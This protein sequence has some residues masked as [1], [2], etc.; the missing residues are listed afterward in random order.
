MDT[1]F[2]FVSL[3]YEIE[4][5]KLRHVS[6]AEGQKRREHVLSWGGGVAHVLGTPGQ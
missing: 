3:F 1:A 4:E 2:L 5:L 6:Y